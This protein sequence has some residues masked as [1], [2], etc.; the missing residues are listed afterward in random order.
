M[1]NPAIFRL[2]PELIWYI[3][4]F[5]PVVQLTP[6][7]TTSRYAQEA[8]D[9][10]LRTRLRWLDGA[11]ET[12][13][14]M[15]LRVYLQVFRRTVNA[16]TRIAVRTALPFAFCPDDF[17]NYDE[18]VQ[19][20][21]KKVASAVTAARNGYRSTLGTLGEAEDAAQKAGLPPPD[22][23]AILQTYWEAAAPELESDA[24]ASKRYL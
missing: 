12:G 7:T 8:C 13:T 21:Y 24:D 1:A 14:H 11:A 23:A 17:R 10:H 18:C 15:N 19:K 9:K 22:S 4:D 2:P 3:L 5:V 16:E 20:F 6:F